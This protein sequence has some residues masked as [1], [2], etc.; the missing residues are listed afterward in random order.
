MAKSVYQGK[1]VC[2][3][4]EISSS[5]QRIGNFRTLLIIKSGIKK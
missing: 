3:T 5:Y 1:N 2:D 4:D